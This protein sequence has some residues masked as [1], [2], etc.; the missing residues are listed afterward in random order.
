MGKSVLSVTKKKIES[1]TK[2]PVDSK[3]KSAPS[4]KSEV[5]SKTTSTS[6]KT[7]TTTTSV[8]VR[9]KKVYT[10]PGQKY[11]PPEEVLNP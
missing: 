7:T 2:Q 10:L 11:D 6:T 9:E 3:H 5:K 8:K 4:I 1:S